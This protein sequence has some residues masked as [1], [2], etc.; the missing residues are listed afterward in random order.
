MGPVVLLAWAGRADALRSRMDRRSL[1]M[2][3]L[4]DACGGAGLGVL[5]RVQGTASYGGY[6]TWDDH[7]VSTK[8][9]VKS[10]LVKT[11]QHCRP[12]GCV[13]NLD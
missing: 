5:G 6:L 2:F 10:N 12:F 11:L 7:P 9:L 4:V 13:D 8:K 1:L 3:M